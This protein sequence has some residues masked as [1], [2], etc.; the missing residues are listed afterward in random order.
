MTVLFRMKRMNLD[1][2]KGYGPDSVVVLRC[3]DGYA[4]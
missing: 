4:W 1:L 2:P 3:V